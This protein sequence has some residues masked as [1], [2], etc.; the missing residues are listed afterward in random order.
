LPQKVNRFL[1][2]KIGIHQAHIITE[3]AVVL[4]ASGRDILSQFFI[5]QLRDFFSGHSHQSLTIEPVSF[6]RRDDCQGIRG[7]NHFFE[8]KVYRLFQPGEVVRFREDKDEISG[9]LG[10]ISFPR[11][12]FVNSRV[13]SCNLRFFYQVDRFD[14]LEDTIFVD[15]EVI[16]CEV[17][18]ESIPFVDAYKGPP[19][20]SL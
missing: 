4:P 12:I 2:R 19:R 13:L 16:Q 10:S 17:I 1:A 11:L 18:N 9:Y 3:H 7:G 14:V 15:F 6:N 8:E 5:Q 20:L